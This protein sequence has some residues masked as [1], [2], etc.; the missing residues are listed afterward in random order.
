MLNSACCISALIFYIWSDRLIRLCS[1]SIHGCQNV[2]FACLRNFEANR[3]WHLQN[4]SR[5]PRNTSIY[6]CSIMICSISTSP[7]HSSESFVTNMT[8]NKKS[9]YAF[10]AYNRVKSNPNDN[11]SHSSNIYIWNFQS[12]PCM[13]WIWHRNPIALSHLIIQPS[14]NSPARVSLAGR[15]GLAVQ[16]AGGLRRFLPNHTTITTKNLTQLTVVMTAASAAA[17]ADIPPPHLI[18]YI[19]F[20]ET[21]QNTKNIINSVEECGEINPQVGRMFAIVAWRSK[22]CLLDICVT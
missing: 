20:R 15:G 1:I 12:A 13:L 10:L 17:A 7:A 3:E 9:R 22:I 21:R 4:R 18:I 2:P 16:P 19:K 14:S 8:K 11:G 6:T 5:Y